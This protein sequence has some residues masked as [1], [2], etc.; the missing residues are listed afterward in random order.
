MIDISS[1]QIIN[2]ASIDGQINEKNELY[3]IGIESLI[4]QLVD[5]SNSKMVEYVKLK[6]QKLKQEQ[7]QKELKSKK[8][9]EAK[10]KRENA[11]FFWRFIVGIIEL[12]VNILEIINDDDREKEDKRNRNHSYNNIFIYKPFIKHNIHNFC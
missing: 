9:N 8:A 3:T 7:A 11:H 10:I 1:G 4:E 2:N 5:D 12:V 6:K